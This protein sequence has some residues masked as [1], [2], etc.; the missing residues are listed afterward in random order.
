[1]EVV[2]GDLSGSEPRA[3]FE[4]TLSQRLGPQA[5]GAGLAQ[6]EFDKTL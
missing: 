5:R 3:K 6:Y 1:M 4:V 2:N